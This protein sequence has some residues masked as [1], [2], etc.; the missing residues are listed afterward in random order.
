MGQSRQR[1]RQKE[2][3]KEKERE[4]ERGRE[5]YLIGR[6]GEPVIVGLFVHFDVLYESL[7]LFLQPSN[8]NTREEKE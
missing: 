3:R 1:K 8:L 6:E 7:V 4:R 2:E 5:G